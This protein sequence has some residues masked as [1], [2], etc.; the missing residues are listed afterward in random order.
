MFFV[1]FLLSHHPQYSWGKHKVP[2]TFCTCLSCPSSSDSWLGAALSM[3]RWRLRKAACMGNR[4]SKHSSFWA[5]PKKVHIGAKS[6]QNNLSSHVIHYMTRS[7]EISFYR[8]TS[9]L[10]ERHKYENLGMTFLVT[11]F[12][13]KNPHF[14]KNNFFRP[15]IIGMRMAH[16]QAL[17]N[18]PMWYETS[19]ARAPA[20]AAQRARAHTHTH[21]HTHTHL[22][23]HADTH[24]VKTMRK[25]REGGLPDW[26]LIRV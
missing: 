25:G 15:V 20:H 17:A 12:N 2:R 6:P 5:S 13:K 21:T 1:S 9:C 22:R 8:T 16:A 18:G 24:C 26:C 19:C 4:T 7:H 11:W 10:Y 14:K 23:T 3:H